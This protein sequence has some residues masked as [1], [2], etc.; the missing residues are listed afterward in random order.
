MISKKNFCK[1]LSELQ[2]Q[3]DIL[4]KLNDLDLIYPEC[5]LYDMCN[6]I[7]EILAN[8]LS[9]DDETRIDSLEQFLFDF[10][11]QYNFGQNYTDYKGDECYLFEYNGVKYAPKSFE[12]LYDVLNH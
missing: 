10:C 3:N 7:P 12:E 6:T 8:E 11:Y 1:L 5:V 2:K 9:N 4:N